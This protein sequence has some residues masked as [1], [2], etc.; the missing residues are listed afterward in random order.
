MKKLKS[1][2][3]TNSLQWKLLSRFFL[4]LMLLLVIM[5]AYQYMTL[6]HVF[7]RILYQ[8][9]TIIKIVTSYGL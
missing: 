5:E 7:L 1:S 3:N 6:K 9:Y 8:Y 4:I 2:L